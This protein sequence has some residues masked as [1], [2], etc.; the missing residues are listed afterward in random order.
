MLQHEAVRTAQLSDIVNIS[1]NKHSFSEL[2]FPNGFPNEIAPEI[3]QISGAY[4][5]SIIIR[6]SIQRI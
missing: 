5:V 3:M 2:R 1:L 6:Q 4:L